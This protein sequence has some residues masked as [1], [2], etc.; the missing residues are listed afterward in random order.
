[1]AGE[2]EPLAPMPTVAGEA[3][4]PA[5]ASPAAVPAAAPVVEQAAPVAA[6]VSEP[7]LLQKFDAEQAEAAK[8][9]IDPE[10]PTEPVVEAK[11]VPDAPGAQDKPTEV[12]PEGTKP[13]G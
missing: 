11:S 12:K 2:A 9:K 6:P 4:A 1:M 8:A 3:P 5:A 10:K 7:T 13:E